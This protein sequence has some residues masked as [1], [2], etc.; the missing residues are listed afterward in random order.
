MSFR[1]RRYTAFERQGIRAF[2][3]L[4]RQSSSR[5]R[6][7]WP[8]WL[9]ALPIS[10]P[11]A[12]PTSSRSCTRC[13]T[14]RL[15]ECQLGG[16]TGYGYDDLGR[17][18]IEPCLRTGIRRRSRSGPHPDQFRHPRQLPSALFGLLRPGDELLSVTGSPYDSLSDTI[19]CGDVAGG[20]RSGS[21]TEF[22]VAYRE[23]AL[24]PD[25]RPDLAGIASSTDAAD[26][27]CLCPEIPRLHHPAARCSQP[28]LPPSAPC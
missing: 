13:R 8:R 21:L 25:G 1:P 14:A 5:A 15:S 4:S 20:H 24:L 16:T 19:G 27:G 28:I 12:K 7:H 22:G 10:G 17:E 18:Q 23:L 11:F 26:A 6:R 2:R 9:V 3:H